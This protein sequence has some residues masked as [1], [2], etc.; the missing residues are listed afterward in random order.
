MATSSSSEAPAETVEDTA[1]EA[2]DLA[3]K[4]LA[5]EISADKYFD[6]V[7]KLAQ[8]SVR[9]EI[10]LAEERCRRVEAGELA[11]AG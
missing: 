8:T 1:S 4:Y 3:N 11:T 6:K 9:A 10:E 7:D 2:V 5:S